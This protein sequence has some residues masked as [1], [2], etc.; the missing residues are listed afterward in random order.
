[1]KHGPLPALIEGVLEAVWLVDCID[2][3]IVAANRAAEAL[4]GLPR[5]QMVG[6]PVVNFAATSQDVFFW[7]DVAAGRTDNIYSETLVTRPDNSIVQ[8]D[9]RVSRLQGPGVPALFVVAMLDRSAQHRVEQELENIIAELRA[10]LESTAD[11]IL[12]LDMDGGIRGYNHRFAELWD[13]PD[14]LLTRRD[15]T[16]VFAWLSEHVVDQDGYSQRFAQIRRSP[17]L[18]AEDLL[19]LRSGRV[20]ER[21]TLPQYARGR[22]IGRVFSFRDITQ[23]L[24][25]E[26]RLKL[27]AS[28]FECSLDAIFVADR[29]LRL[30]AANPTFSRLTGF[31]QEEIEGLASDRFLAEQGNQDSFAAVRASLL[32]KGYWQGELWA[33]RKSGEAYPCLLSVVRVREDDAR[34][35]SFIGFFKD[36]TEAIAAKRRIEELAFTD[37]LTGLPNRVMLR[38]RF[39]FAIAH[40]GRTRSGFAVLFI[41]LDRFKQIND[42]LGHAFGDR[43]LVEVAERLKHNLRQIDTAARLGGDEFVLLLNQV[44]SQGAE[45]AA[46]RVLADIVRPVRVDEMSFALT[47][48]IG[49]AMYPDDGADMDELIKNADSAMYAVKERGRADFRFYQRQMNIGLLSRMKLDQAL[50]QALD[51]GRLELRYQPKLRLSDQRVVGVEALLRWSDDEYGE[52]LPARFI[53]VAEESGAIIP[54]GAWVIERAAGQ[55]ALWH[56]A[57]LALPVAVNI[58]AMQFNQ[59]NFVTGMAEL[60]Q[61]HGLPGSML[62]LELTESILIADADEAMRRLTALRELGIRLSIDDFGTGYSSLSY[63][64]R[65]PIERLKIDRSFVDDIPGNPEDEAIAI[66]II[67]LGHALRLTVTAEGV[68]TAE[69]EAFLQAQGCNELQGFRYAPALTAEALLAQF[70][71]RIARSP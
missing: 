10:T 1:M 35:D 27:A 31:E 23:R 24:A 9:R 42:S 67:Q 18:E 49:I 26:A 56:A 65:F 61:R 54:L 7:E 58:S 52:V 34:Q 19:V 14:V 51:E 43:V 8:V 48:S 41:D 5:E 55:A 59:S 15:D 17:L 16:A 38:E 12:V 11:G 33:R 60:L 39:E 53:P 30:V 45:T 71:D 69:Q 28:V 62:E 68:E 20:L 3:R 57:G 32:E 46:R 2:L 50:R 22:P 36:L 66:A 64:K 40:A 29:T 25:D 13:L 70:D 37:A 47:A 6:Q 44:D 63:L 4:L 21:V